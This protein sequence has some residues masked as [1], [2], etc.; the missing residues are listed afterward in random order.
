[1]KVIGAGLLRTG[2]MSTKS[3]MEK[4]GYPCHPMTE[5]PK[6]NGHLEAWYGLVSGRTAMDW[7]AIFLDYEATVDVPACFYYEEL[8]QEFPKAK[9]L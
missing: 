6:V 8:M 4:I 7:K 1:M 2:T 5:T 3:A 9:V